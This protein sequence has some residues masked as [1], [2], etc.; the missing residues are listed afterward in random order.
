MDKAQRAELQRQL[1]RLADGDR[2]AFHPAFVLFWP[3]LRRFAE[4]HLGA[5]DAEDAAQQ[6]LLKAFFNA[7]R[8]DRDRDAL[9][10]VLGIAAHEIQSIQRKRRRERPEDEDA[11]RNRRDGSPSPEEQAIARDLRLALDG[12]LVDLS[13]SDAETL[14]CFAH[15]RRPEG[16]AAATFR[17]RLER[18][19]GRLRLAWRQRHGPE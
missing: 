16:I 12:A 17:K 11:A 8:F 13:P 1:T 10:W 6:A 15:D 2:E 18:A 3:L 4:R 7:A 19:L 14:S 5:A 9:S